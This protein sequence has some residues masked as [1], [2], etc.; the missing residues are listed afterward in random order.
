MTE[1]IPQ[2]VTPEPAQFAV[3]LKHISLLG[4][5]DASQVQKLCSLLQQVEYLDGEQIFRRGDQPSHIYIVQSGRVRID[6]GRPDHPLSDIHFDAG[7]CFGE[8][9]VIGIQPFGRCHCRG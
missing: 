5:L 7:E 4:G 9:S 8:T 3:L 2:A 1:K 6:F